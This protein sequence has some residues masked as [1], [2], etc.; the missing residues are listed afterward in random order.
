MPAPPRG[1]KRRPA[2]ASSPSPQRDKFSLMEAAQRQRRYKTAGEP[3]RTK[4]ALLWRHHSSPP[5]PGRRHHPPPLRPAPA[6]SPFTDTDHPAAPCAGGPIF[7][8]CAQRQRTHS[9]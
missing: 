3:S 4:P 5:C 9:A 1:A 2:G 7:P 8:R 6:A